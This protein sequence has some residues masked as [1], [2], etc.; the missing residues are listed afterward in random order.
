MTN[1]W[2]HGAMFWVGQR[3]FQEPSSVG[4]PFGCFLRTVETL[5]D[6]AVS[7]FVTAA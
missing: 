5:I 1:H 3:V 6:E 2:S 7:L 4:R